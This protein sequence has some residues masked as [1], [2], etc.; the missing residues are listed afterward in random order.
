MDSLLDFLRSLITGGFLGQAVIGTLVWGLIAF[1]ILQKTPVDNRLYDAGFI[2]L[3][4]LFHVAQVAVTT[5][6]AVKAER[7]AR[8]CEEAMING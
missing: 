4:Y 7:Y 8:E 6:K 2:V 5:R 3:G 1:L